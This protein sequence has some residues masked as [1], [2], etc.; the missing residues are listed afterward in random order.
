M[1]SNFAAEDET[2]A[3][4]MDCPYQEAPYSDASDFQEK[5]QERKAHGYDSGM[6]AIFQKA[7]QN[8]IDDEV[9]Q[10]MD[11][12]WHC[13]QVRGV[14]LNAKNWLNLIL[15][16]VKRGRSCATHMWSSLWLIAAAP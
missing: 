14:P 7:G 1:V 15:D 16:D 13:W 2:F 11:H 8:D 10:K 12:S 9:W 5:C 6:G 4:S 3:S